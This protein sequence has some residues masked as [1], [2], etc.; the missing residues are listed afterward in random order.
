MR[1]QFDIRPD[2]VLSV[3]KYAR[4]KSLKRSQVYKLALAVGLNVLS[5]CEIPKPEKEEGRNHVRKS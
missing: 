1:A 5:A 3:R 4:A 2:Q